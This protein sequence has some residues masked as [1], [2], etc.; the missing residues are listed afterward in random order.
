MRS[1]ISSGFVTDCVISLMPLFS[2]I[3]PTHNRPGFLARAVTSVQQQHFTDWELV[4][5]DDGSDHANAQLNQSILEKMDDQRIRYVYQASAGPGAA[6]NY[7]LTLTNTPYFLLLDDDDYFLPNHL[8]NAADWLAQ[9]NYPV[10]V[11]NTGLLNEYADGRKEK[12]APLDASKGQDAL[13]QFWQVPRNLTPFVFPHTLLNVVP[14]DPEERIIEDF[15]WLAR[16]LAHAEVHALTDYTAVYVNHPHNRNTLSIAPN[17]LS[18][19][20]RVVESAYAYQQTA[21]RVPVAVKRSLLCHQ[22]WH[23]ARQCW[24]SGAWKLGLTGFWKGVGYVQLGN[25]KELFY[26]VFMALRF[27]LASFSPR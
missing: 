12:H 7:G 23:Y 14:I 15:A 11:L 9:N 5:V 10:T 16:V 21:Q 2:I 1:K 13:V 3:I 22:C 4:I 6:R 25:T 18:G 27:A 20:I 26:T 24:G 17:W 19:R 8:G